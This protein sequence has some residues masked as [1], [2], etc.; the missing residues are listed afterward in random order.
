MELQ[1]EAT[2]NKAL[3]QDKLLSFPQTHGQN[4]TS[5]ASTLENAVIRSVYFLSRDYSQ[6][7]VHLLS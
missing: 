3:L 1:K 4:E 2:K 5:L 7:E 6:I